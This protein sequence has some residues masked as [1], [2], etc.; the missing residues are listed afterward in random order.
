[1]QEEGESDSGEANPSS[2]PLT[3]TLLVC[4]AEDVFAEDD[5]IA[6]CPSYEREFVSLAIGEYK[7]KDG[8]RRIAFAA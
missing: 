2:R 3:R 4:S 1:M 8:P 6:R 5:G 7:A